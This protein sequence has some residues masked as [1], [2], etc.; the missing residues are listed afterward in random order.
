M[1]S[2][3]EAHCQR[4][5]RSQ[6]QTTMG[7]WTLRP[8]FGFFFPVD[9]RTRAVVHAIQK[10]SSTSLDVLGHCAVSEL[11]QCFHATRQ[12]RDSTREVQVFFKVTEL[13]QCPRATE[14]AERPTLLPTAASKRALLTAISIF[15]HVPYSPFLLHS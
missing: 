7:C 11:P 10:L 3:D 6:R 4:L 12:R 13:G 14:N 1:Q 5:S 2:R 15:H 8:W 9:G